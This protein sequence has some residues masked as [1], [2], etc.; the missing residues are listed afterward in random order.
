MA[1]GITTFGLVGICNEGEWF[2]S[3]VEIQCY[4]IK[5][6]KLKDQLTSLAPS[7]KLEKLGVEQNSLFYWQ[8]FNGI[9]GQV[10]NYHKSMNTSRE[11][12]NISAFTVAELGEILRSSGAG[13][14]I[15]S[16]DANN[17][18]KPWKAKNSHITIWE[19][20]EANA[21][22]KMLIYLKENKLM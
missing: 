8:W 12:I 7:K 2:Y 13:D 10:L 4:Q 17:G 16:Y 20:T 15:Y 6:M 18:Y 1:R 9:K 5:D 22:A 19:K 14:T 11:V 3:K 21:R